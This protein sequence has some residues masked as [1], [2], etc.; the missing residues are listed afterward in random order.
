L[1][2]FRHDN[3]DFR[4][5][6]TGEGVPFIFQH[7][8]GADV[9]Q[10]FGLFRPPAGIRMLTFDCRGHGRTRGLGEREKLGIQTFTADLAAFLDHL[11]IPAAVVGG[12]SMGAAVAL[13]FALRHPERAKG[14]VLSRPAGVERP[15]PRTFEIYGYIVR[16]IREHGPRK[17]Q[18]LYRKSTQFRQIEQEAPATANMLLKQFEH[19]RLEDTLAIV[20]RLPED[21]PCFE[22]EDLKRLRVPA[23]VLANRQDPVHPFEVGQTLAAA[24]PGAEFQELTPKSINRDQHETEVQRHL[25]DFLQRHFLPAA[26]AEKSI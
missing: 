13:N 26:A 4:Y 10:T 3:I 8:L 17:G 23:L 20:E 25:E 21:R 2:F 14:L 5:V 22:R 15:P 1:P 11:E 19:P 18:E 12:I 16:L 9:N 6:Q 24:I 7:G